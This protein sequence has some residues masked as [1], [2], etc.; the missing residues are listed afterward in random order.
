MPLGAIITSS[1]MSTA[2]GA[3]VVA[4]A[5]GGEAS[6]EMLWL[7]QQ[8][9]IE[10]SSP[11][12]SPAR[13]VPRSRGG[14]PYASFSFSSSSSMAIPSPLFP[15]RLQQ[16]MQQPSSGASSPAAVTLQLE[17]PDVWDQTADSPGGVN[18]NAGDRYRYMLQHQH[19]QGT[20]GNT[21]SSAASTARADP[22]F[23]LPVAASAGSS[24]VHAVT[25]AAASAT[26]GVTGSTRNPQQQVQPVQ[27][28]PSSRTRQS[29]PGVS[30]SPQLSTSNTLLLGSPQQQQ[31]QRRSRP[32]ATTAQ[33]AN[34]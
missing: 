15:L 16:Q 10:S 19:Q 24:R 20:D 4:G 33:T 18:A 11:F 28:H 17:P 6:M 13:P 3:A 23:L 22:S 5:G 21:S 25:G 9:D 34:M 32:I 26:A 31:Q 30:S 2:A 12:S 27:H 8:Y 14:T 1:S 7:E 29:I